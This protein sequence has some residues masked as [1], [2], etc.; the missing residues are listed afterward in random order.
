MSKE[1][2][3]RRFARAGWLAIYSDDSN[4]TRFYLSVS[5]NYSSRLYELKKK[6]ASPGEL[7][8]MHMS[9]ST[10]GL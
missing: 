9:S 8:A 4:A 5:A 1:E 2:L 10:G 7:L 3:Q 6:N